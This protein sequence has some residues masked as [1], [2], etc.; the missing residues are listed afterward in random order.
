MLKLDLQFFAGEKTEKATPKKRQD[1]RK[2]GQVA[3]SQDIN[4][5]LVF[6]FLFL[7][8]SFG[9]KFILEQFLDILAEGF[10]HNLL[11]DITEQNVM[12]VFI[13][14]LPKIAF[15]VLPIMAVALI[16]GILTNY[17]QIGFLFSTET[18]KFDLK[19]INPITGAKRIFA[20]RAL[21][22]LFKSVLKISCIGLVTFFILWANLKEVLL[23]AQKGVQDAMPTI[24]KLIFQ[25]GIAASLMLLFIAI[26]DYAY[27]RYDYEKN[28]R[29]SKQDIKDEHKNTEGDP[30]I[31][32][33]I[34]QKQR[35]MAMSRMMQDVPTADVIITNP[36]HYAVALKYDEQK[37]DA[38]YVVAS[39][40]D[41]VAQ[42]IKG[43]AAQHNITMIENRPLARGLY[44]QAEVGQVIP[45]EFFKA[46][47]EILAYV[48][49]IQKK[50]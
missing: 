15:A 30:Q 4:T 8:F 29:M 33:K 35:A 18:L 2:K 49:R 37:A 10:S 34:K 46:V 32:S 6:L 38:P 36:T 26:L 5:A 1:S 41:F 27:Q 25:M 20:M 21:V 31:R 50:I 45:E 43:V 3:K 17:A 12:K 16:G 44:E 48:Y 14:L 19:K 13:D 9:A 28:I 47:A 39:G 22:E 23:L 42:K 24:G 7:Y 40:V 11:F